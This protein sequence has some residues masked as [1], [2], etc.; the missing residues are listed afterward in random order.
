MLTLILHFSRALTSSGCDGLAIYVWW[1]GGK[2][3]VRPRGSP[4]DKRRDTGWNAKWTLLFS[5]YRQ[6]HTPPP[7]GGYVD[8]P[9]SPSALPAMRWF[10][11][12]FLPFAES[13]GRLCQGKWKRE[14]KGEGSKRQSPAV[15]TNGPWRAG[16]LGRARFKAPP[17]SFLLLH[18]EILFS[19]FCFFPRT[20]SHADGD[21]LGRGSS[22]TVKV[23]GL[24]RKRSRI[25]PGRITARLER[26]VRDRIRRVPRILRVAMV[27]IRC[28]CSCSCRKGETKL[29]VNVGRPGEIWGKGEESLEK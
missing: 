13:R 8:R 21:S 12:H 9:I 6:V 4:G 26:N 15:W 2:P 24:S 5:E 10:C 29:H 17:S 27:H 23:W 1:T 3:R 18:L 28:S 7:C 25:N 22:L 16:T 11:P 14:R 19:H 20:E